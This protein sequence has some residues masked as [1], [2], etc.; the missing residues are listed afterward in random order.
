MMMGKKAPLIANS[1]KMRALGNHFSVIAMVINSGAT[2]ESPSMAGKEMND[3]KR[4]ILR[5][6]RSCLSL[7]SAIW[8]NKGC[9]TLPTMPEM[10]E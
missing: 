2:R 3:V 10:S 6:T 8:A 5:K 4:S 9:A 7:S 1:C